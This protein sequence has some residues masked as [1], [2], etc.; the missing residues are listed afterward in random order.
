MRL[1]PSGK[2]C[3]ESTVVHQQE[4]ETLDDLAME[5]EL[6]DEDQPIMYVSKVGLE[7]TWSDHI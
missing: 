2:G 7:H 1:L 3:D 4:K 5:I 6:A